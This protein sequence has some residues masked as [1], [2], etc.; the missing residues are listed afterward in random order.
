MAKPGTSFVPNLFLPAASSQSCC[1]LHFSKWLCFTSNVFDQDN[2]FTTIF[3]LRFIALA[4]N[5]IS[6][7]Q[8]STVKITPIHHHNQI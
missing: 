1:Q 7:S 8:M 3:P 5:L 2:F 6:E 4:H